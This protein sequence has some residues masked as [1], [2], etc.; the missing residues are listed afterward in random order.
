MGFLVGRVFLFFCFVLANPAEGNLA[1]YFTRCLGL[2][3]ASAPLHWI[4]CFL[5]FCVS[6]ELIVRRDTLG[7]SHVQGELACPWCFTCS[8]SAWCWCHPLQGPSL[9]QCAWLHQGNPRFHFSSAASPKA[10]PHTTTERAPSR[11]QCYLHLHLTSCGGTE[12]LHH[13]LHQ[14]QTFPCWSV[15]CH[16]LQIRHLLL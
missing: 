7:I 11:G 13:V 15:T 3:S 4:F 8:M 1:E 5:Q 6:S 10:A 12:Q 9:P 2:K 16:V 14:A